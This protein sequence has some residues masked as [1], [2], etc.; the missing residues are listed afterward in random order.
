MGNLESLLK[1]KWPRWAIAAGIILLFIAVVAKIST[2]GSVQLL[3]Q[4]AVI[5]NGSGINQNAEKIINNYLERKDPGFE[6]ERPDWTKGLHGAE[7]VKAFVDAGNR[8]DYR[9]ACSLLSRSAC[10]SSIGSNLVAFGNFWSKTDAGIVAE[11]WEAEKQPLPS[12]QRV[13]CGRLTY[14][15]KGDLHPLPITEIYQ[16]RTRFREDGSEQIET[17][18]SEGTLKDGNY[19]SQ[20]VTRNYYCR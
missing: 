8:A 11:V 20:G 7:I 5:Q 10:N 1:R 18:T 13:Y 14:V 19:I 6:N 17:R 16:F 3:N 9:G 2:S 12:G 4:K 15:L